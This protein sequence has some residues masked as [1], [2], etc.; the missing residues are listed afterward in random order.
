MDCRQEYEKFRNKTEVTN[1]YNLLAKKEYLRSLS[2][3]DKESVARM[4]SAMIVAFFSAWDIQ[5]QEIERLKG[6]RWI[7]VE[8]RLPE[9]M[10]SVITYREESGSVFPAIYLNEKFQAPDTFKRGFSELGGV[11]THWQPLP[12]PPKGVEG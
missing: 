12:E 4:D 6:D 2:E 3:G 11:V 10:D 7:S 9:N 8:D 1:E 5:Q